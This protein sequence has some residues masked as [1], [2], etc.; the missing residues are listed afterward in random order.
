MLDNWDAAFPNCEPIAH[1]MREQF[2]PRWVRFHSLPES[3]RY[4]END[5]EMAE[6]L[7]R[8]NTILGDLLGEDCEVVLLTTAATFD[9]GNAPREPDFLEFDPHAVPWRTVPM[10]TCDDFDALTYWYISASLWT[11]ET[12]MFDPVVRLSA[13]WETVNVMMADP[14]CRWMLHPYDG[15]M[16][17]ILATSAERDC[18]KSAFPDWLS[19]R[20]DGM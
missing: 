7:H 17:V 10:H 15:G 4:P 12:G 19:A 5:T 1:L 8:H 3:K 13:G 14:Y 18:L 16:D 11:W 6:V 9:L 2:R 20:E